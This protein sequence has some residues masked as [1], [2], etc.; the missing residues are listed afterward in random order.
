MCPRAGAPADPSPA[1]PGGRIRTSTPVSGAPAD[2]S[3]ARTSAGVAVVTC[4]PASVNPYV[5]AI[6]HPADRAR[7]ARSGG[8]AAPPSRTARRVPGGRAPAASS[9]CSI[10]GTSERCVTASSPS[11]RTTEAASNRGPASATVAPAAAALSGTASPPTCAQASVASHRS[12]A[13]NPRRSFEAPA[14]A[15]SDRHS[16]TTKRGRPSVPEVGRMTP[17]P[18]R[19]PRVGGAAGAGRCAGAGSRTCRA[20]SPAPG[21]ASGRDLHPDVGHAA[22]FPVRAAAGWSAAT[23]A[24]RSCAVQSACAGASTRAPPGAASDANAARATAPAGSSGNW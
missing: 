2:R 23:K 22:A 10:A 11:D 1:S 6:G 7:S 21:T 4:D 17:A 19:S 12:P 3:P 9:P 14:F 18:G 8:V 15:R 24:S 20:I 5:S 16:W 13:A